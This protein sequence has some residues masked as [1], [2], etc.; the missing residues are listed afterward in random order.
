MAADIVHHRSCYQEYLNPKKLKRFEDL[1]EELTTGYTKAYA[2]L[3]EELETSVLK[4]TKVAFLPDLRNRFT[5]LLRQQGEE[6]DVYRTEKVERYLHI[7]ANAL[8]FFSLKVSL[9]HV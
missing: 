4:G 9:T 5:Y 3:F 1:P 8:L 2:L 7:L 6:N